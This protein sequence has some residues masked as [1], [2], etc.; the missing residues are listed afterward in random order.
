[1][2]VDKITF[3][4]LPMDVEGKYHLDCVSQLS[5]WSDFVTIVWLSHKNT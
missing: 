5:Y 3:L 2:E 1:M 4:A